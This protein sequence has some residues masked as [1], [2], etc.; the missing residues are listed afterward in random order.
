MVAGLDTI[1]LLAFDYSADQKVQGE[2]QSPNPTFIRCIFKLNR[3]K[4]FILYYFIVLC[5]ARRFAVL[6]DSGRN[7]DGEKWQCLSSC[8]INSKFQR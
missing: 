3:G 6:L 1:R 8:M 5:S 2:S 7:R 4:V